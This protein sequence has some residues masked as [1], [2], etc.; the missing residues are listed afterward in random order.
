MATVPSDQK[1]HTVAA[2]VQT[3]E[4]GSSL[5]N[6]QREIF[7]MEDITSTVRPYNVFTALLTQ[8]GGDDP[9]ELVD[10]DAVTKGVTYYIDGTGI[11]ADFSNVGGPKFEGTTINGT[12][13]VAINN[14]VPNNYDEGY[15]VYNT[16]APVATVLENTIGNIWFSYQDIGAYLVNSDG[17]FTINKTFELINN[18]LTLEEGYLGISNYNNNG[19]LLELTSI[20]STFTRIN[21]YFNNTPIE[22]RV[23]E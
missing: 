4:R 3:V 13:F 10:G 1:F 15:L 21:G 12:Y 14:N 5:A 17:L 23:Y 19:N 9:L 7:T 22:I 16:G 2:N 18:I 11:N 6:S 8:S 20:D